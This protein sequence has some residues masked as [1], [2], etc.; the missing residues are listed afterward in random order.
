MQLSQNRS[1]RYFAAVCTIALA[2][3]LVSELVL[4]VPA[5]RNQ[6]SAIWPPA[7]ISTAALLIVG[8]WAWPG[9]A[10]GG[11]WSDMSQG[12]TIIESLGSTTGVTLQAV[13]ATLILRRIHFQNSLQ[14]LRDVMGFVIG[15][16]IASSLINATISASMLLLIRAIDQSQFWQYWG[17]FWLGDSMGV[18]IVT[19]LILTVQHQISIQFRTRMRQQWGET[20]LWM[21]L[22]LG[23]SAVVYGLDFNA[24]I[25]Q[26]P[27]EYLPYPI[28][29]WAALR[30][31]VAGGV[32]GNFLLSAVAA[33]G[34]LSGLGPF[35]EKATS[36]GQS[37]LLLQAFLGVT[38][39]TTLVIAAAEAQRQ[40]TQNLLRRSEASL[41]NAQRI[42]HIGNWDFDLMHQTWCWS[43]ELY[44]LLGLSRMTMPPHPDLLVSVVH[45]ADQARVRSHLDRALTQLTPYSIDYRLV[46]PDGT[47]RLVHE[48]VEVQPTAISGTLQDITE[49]KH[50]E[51]ALRES[52][53]KFYKAFG[54]S[55]DSI[56]ISTLEEGRFI[57]VNPSC[58]R[59]LGYQRDEMVGRTSYELNLWAD[60]NDRERIKE[61]VQREGAV[62]NQE[63][64]F[65][66]KSGQVIIALTSI[67]IIVLQNQPCLLCV[68][69]DVTERKLAEENLRL[70]N[71]RDRLLGEMALR[72][73]QSL[74]LH[75]MLDTTVAEVRRFLRADRVFLGH[76]DCWGKGSV[77]AESV[78]AAFPSNMGQIIDPEIYPEIQEVFRQ[79]RVCVVNDTSLIEKSPFFEECVKQYLV[80]AVVSVP[81]TLDDRLFGVLVAHQCAHTREWTPFETELLERLA[82]QVAIAIQQAELYA[83]V[84]D[85][86]VNLERQV[87]ERTAELQQKMQ[88]LQ[89]LNALRDFFL[90]AV[91]H[92]LSTTVKGTLMVLTNLQHQPGE[93]I[94]IPR[95]ILDRMIQGGER[96]LGKLTSLQEAYTIKTGGI[97]LRCQPL[98]FDQIVEGMVA[99]MQPM[100]T[101][102]QA[103]LATAVAPGLPT[104]VADADELRR[105]LWQLLNNAIIHNPPRVHVTLTADCRDGMLQ[106]QVQDN[107]V[108]IS[109][110]RCDRIFDLCI[111][112][113]D[114]PKLTGVSLGLYLCRQIIAAQGGDIGIHSV[115]GQGTTVWF[116]LPMLNETSFN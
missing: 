69:R 91:A 111:G 44:A 3:Y 80:K 38:T 28:V 62:R 29:I 71:E 73:R 92:D 18:L 25:A 100:L 31:G 2:Y 54:F 95:N 53:E 16:A 56:T 89:E 76:F 58:L 51:E 110:E 81:I 68:A 106:C 45:P 59:M 19:P 103:T 109:P 115:V 72:I 90:H 49:Q 9:V 94:S 10:I 20:M 99:K 112:C 32:L 35:V 24:A 37:I 83:Q 98:A 43:S 39:V 4:L 27:L 21:G 102:H 74:D 101:K 30:F 36:S 61:I 11:L 46:L 55:P 85:L 34:T 5:L 116:T 22:L 86:N 65:L 104:V 8:P 77:V 75:E 97:D 87:V 84:Q 63:F 114:D 1:W 70:A 41:A 60:Y 13:A 40:Q 23:I 67:E 105:V 50:S 17:T 107:G 14:R 15:G 57:E 12:G 93:T 96:Q 66:T 7:G 79:N 113:P 33:T 82:T 6:A 108:G 78:A 64:S 26:Y 47:E 42:A 48:H 52:Q 88:E